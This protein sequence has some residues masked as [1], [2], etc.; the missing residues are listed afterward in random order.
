MPERIGLIGRAEGGTFFIDE[1]GEVPPEILAMLLRALDKDGTYYRFGSHVARIANVRFVV[2]TNRE[3]STLKHDFLPR[4][5]VVIE[6]PTL[7]D[8]REDVPL[9][10]RAL[11]LALAK[12]APELAERFVIE[13][14]GS[15]DVRFSQS[16]MTRLMRHSYAANVRELDTLLW[17][18]VTASKKSVLVDVPRAERII[19]RSV[20]DIAADEIRSLLAERKWNVSRTAAAMGISRSALVRRMNQLGIR[21][22]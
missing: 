18:S 7:N 17:E 22:N 15:H 6:V 10:A 1:V 9:I 5:R 11:V 2:A 12:D 20:D 19:V 21:K 4:F 13:T 14:D 8:R 16:F 3:L